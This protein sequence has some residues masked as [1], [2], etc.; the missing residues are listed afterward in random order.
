M[1]IKI[2][3]TAVEFG[4]LIRKCEQASYGGHCSNCVLSDLCCACAGNDEMGI[5]RAVSV[6]IVGDPHNG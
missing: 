6:K 5:E 2:E 3:C 4:A 1:E